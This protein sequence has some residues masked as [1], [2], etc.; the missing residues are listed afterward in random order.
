MCEYMYHVHHHMWDYQDSFVDLAVAF[1]LY[2][3][4]LSD[5][6]CQ[7]VDSKHYTE[8]ARTLNLTL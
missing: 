2:M 3:D 8:T 6:S 4:W 1:H 5:S 7:G